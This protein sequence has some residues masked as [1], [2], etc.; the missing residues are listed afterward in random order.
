[1]VQT[2]YNEVTKILL[3][4][5]ERFYNG[6]DELVPFYDE[7]IALIPNNF[8]IGIITNNNQSIKKL[9]EKFKHKK[10]DFLGLKGWDE[11]WLRDCIGFNTKDHIV[12]PQ[13]SPSYCKKNG[14]YDYF[15]KINGLSNTLVRNFLQK[16]TISLKLI[17][18]GGNMVCNEQFVYLTD[19]VYL[20]N[21]IYSH[22][23]VDTLIKNY[24][25]LEP[26]IIENNKSDVIGHMDAYL[27]FIDNQRAFI[28][29]YPSFPFLKED[30]DFI[31]RVDESVA[32]NGIER[33][34]LFDRPIDEA[35][36]C[37]CNTNKTKPCFYSARGNFLNFL[38]LNN[39]II[40][41]EYN[42]PTK[43]ETQYYNITNQET[44]EGLGFDV[45]RINCD[46]LA[47]FGGVL[48]CISY[49]V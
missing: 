27:S 47:K 20:D 22:N 30:I 4:Y 13:Y 1:M 25:G 5:P 19:K 6:Y 46:V 9:E 15:K 8:Q 10:I 41:P 35:A 21:P 37:G 34:T 3:A 26:I 43:K 7:L 14:D 33:I 12:K 45:L 36:I 32:S 16:D 38:R 39:T 48:H 40:L 2:D 31:K 28:P 18:D 49:T 44:F 11:I 29:E 23:E 24:T 42:L 17:I